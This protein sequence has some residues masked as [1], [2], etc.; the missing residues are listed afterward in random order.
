MNLAL[1]SRICANTRIRTL[2]IVYFMVNACIYRNFLFTV[3]AFAR[4]DLRY[5]T[6]YYMPHTRFIYISLFVFTSR[7]YFIDINEWKKWNIIFVGNPMQVPFIVARKI[8]YDL[9]TGSYQKTNIQL[10]Y[11]S[12][13]W[14]SYYSVVSR[15]FRGK[16]SRKKTNSKSTSKCVLSMDTIIQEPFAIIF[17]LYRKQPVRRQGKKRKNRWREGYQSHIYIRFRQMRCMYPHESKN[18]TVIY[19]HAYTLICKHTCFIYINFYT[20]IQIY[21]YTYA[22]AYIFSPSY[23]YIIHISMHLCMYRNTHTNTHIHIYIYIYIYTHIHIYIYTHTYIYIYLLMS[24][25][26]YKSMYLDIN[27]HILHIVMYTR[28]WRFL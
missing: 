17:L 6:T 20:C 3:R 28:C 1:L 12:Y 9:H 24:L 21:V 13:L 8:S 18:I 27:T 25:D 22:Y 7:Q 5:F 2:V 19:I 26:I 15:R 14:L 4:S 10:Y 11:N 23:V 16:R